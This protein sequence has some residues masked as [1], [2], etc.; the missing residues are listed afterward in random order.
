MTRKKPYYKIV[1]D[2]GHS[3]GELPTYYISLAEAIEAA[4]EWWSEMVR[5]DDD[6]EEAVVSYS[7]EVIRVD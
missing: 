1:W 2:N 7:G 5:I 4:K 3:S 6:P